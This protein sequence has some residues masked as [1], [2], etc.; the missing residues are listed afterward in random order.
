M[1]ANAGRILLVAIALTIN[2]PL[3]IFFWGCLAYFFCETPGLLFPGEAIPLDCG[4]WGMFI[5]MKMKGGPPSVA[6][7]SSR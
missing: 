1:N 4:R 3:S 2:S 5:I 7:M 6:P